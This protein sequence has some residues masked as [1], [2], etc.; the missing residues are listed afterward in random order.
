MYLEGEGI[1]GFIATNR[2]KHSDKFAPAQR[3]APGQRTIKPGQ[4]RRDVKK[5]RTAE[6]NRSKSQKKKR[7]TPTY[8]DRLIVSIDVRKDTAPNVSSF[9]SVGIG[10]KTQGLLTCS[11]GIHM[12]SSKGIMGT[13]MLYLI[14]PQHIITVP[15]TRLNKENP[16]SD[17]GNCLAI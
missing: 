1:D 10:G 15:P 13:I 8:P 14:S 9:F 6:N 17:T 11:N 4:N 5:G 2:Q 12:L 16:D 3:S 7:P